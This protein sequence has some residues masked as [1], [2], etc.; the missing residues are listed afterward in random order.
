MMPFQKD[1]IKKLSFSVL[2][3]LTILLV[4][5]FLSGLGIINSNLIPTPIKV[6]QAIIEWAKSGE[7]I[8]DFSTSIWRGITGLLIGSSIGIFLGL[9]TGRNQTLDLILTPALN[10]FKAF[11]PVAML[12][13][14]ITFFGIGDFSKIFSISFATVFPLWVNTHLGSS[15]VP[16]EFIRS[17]TLLSK[18]KTKIFFGII[19]P[20]SM[21]SIIAGFRI[22]IAISFI[23]LYVSELAGAS[24][25][26]G[27]QISSSHLAYRMDKMLGALIVLGLTASMIDLVF[28][29]VVKRF[30]PWVQL[31]KVM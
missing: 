15:T 22:S 7:L 13:V 21:N 19:I 17:A 28:N 23:M 9:F 6:A 25:G 1:N 12:P 16:V 24:S 3:I 11:P 29:L 30:F 10:V 26:L 31:K 14:F 27:Y 20:A 18:S 2:S 4:W 8:R 5:Q